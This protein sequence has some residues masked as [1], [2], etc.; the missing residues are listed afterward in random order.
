MNFF[1]YLKDNIRLFVFYIV[2]IAFITAMVSFDRK[3]RMLSSNF[4]YMIVV[5][6]VIFAFYVFTDYIIKYAHMKKLAQQKESINEVPVL[7]NPVDYKDEVYCGI[8][9]NLFSCY[10]DSVS[11]IKND[12][13]EDQEFMTAWVHEVKTPI[14]TIQLLIESH[15]EGQKTLESIDEEVQK[16]DD[17]VEKA[18]YYSRGSDFS[19]DYMISEEKIKKLVN[20]SIKKHSVIFIRKHIRPLNSIPDDFTVD[21]DKKWLLFIIDQIVSNALKYTNENGCIS[22]KSD[23]NDSEKVLIIEDNGVGIKSE[24]LKRIF[25]KSFTGYNGR[26]NNLKATGMG[27]YLSQ[28]LARKLGHNITIESVFGK[29]TKVYIHFPVWDDYYDVTNM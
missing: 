21:T 1:K 12:F 18:L 29:G 22:F 8:I 13:K 9:Q 28:K 10:T 23:K 11:K 4:N 19:K 15:D 20:E 2:L 16:I 3:S 14:T 26:N 25:N 17:Y 24:D 27:L 6:T 5:S 7:P